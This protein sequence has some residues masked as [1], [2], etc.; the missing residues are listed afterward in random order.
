[1]RAID[2]SK[3]PRLD[4]YLFALG[5]EHVGETV[6][7]LLADH[8]GA[9]EPLF[10]A[11]E[12]ALQE[13]HGIGPEVA[14]SV[15][16]FFTGAR[17]RRVLDR[18]KQAGVCPVAEK[19]AKGPQPLAGEIVIFTGTLERL[20]RPEAARKAEDAGARVA[21]SISKKVTLV[22]AGPGAGSKLDEAKKHGIRV[23]DEAA[24]LE[25]IEEAR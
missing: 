12:E 16:R 23:I 9:V 20:T 25:R 14:E 19:K 22:V 24:F 4:R 7:R 5:I 6:A 11:D 18:L 10:A 15:R 2:A 13:I 3:R 8:Y 17:N 21:S 1:M